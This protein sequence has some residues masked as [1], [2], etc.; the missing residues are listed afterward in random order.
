MP[1]D[2]RSTWT[3]REITQKSTS[4][5]QIKLQYFSVL[6]GEMSNEWRQREH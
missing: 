6:L 4:A 3:R 1:P 2:C 5:T